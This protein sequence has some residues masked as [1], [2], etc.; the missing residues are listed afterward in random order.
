MGNL[1]ER[2]VVERVPEADVVYIY[3]RR[4]PPACPGGTLRVAIGDGDMI[5]CALLDLDP[6]MSRTGRAMRQIY[7]DSVGCPVVTD[8]TDVQIIEENG[9]RTYE[10]SNG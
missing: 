2:V 5:A 9:R 3:T 8:A 4:C 6:V 7:S 1:F 10:V